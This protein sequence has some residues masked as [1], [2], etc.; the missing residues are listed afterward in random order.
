MK[1]SNELDL[2]YRLIDALIIVVGLL[3]F[4]VLVTWAQQRDIDDAVQYQKEAATRYAHMLAQCMNG[5]LLYDK[6]GDK[7]YACDKVVEITLNK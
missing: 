5:K 7:L 1:P 2:R 3:I 6:S 4:L